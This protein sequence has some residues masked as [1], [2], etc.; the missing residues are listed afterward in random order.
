MGLTEVFGLIQPMYHVLM[1]TPTCCPHIS[2]G[3]TNKTTMG[4][5]NIKFEEL[6]NSNQHGVTSVNVVGGPP[7]SFYDCEITRGVK[8]EIL[9]HV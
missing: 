9:S 5:T 2:I 4:T 7:L 3:G 1:Y 6:M 8:F